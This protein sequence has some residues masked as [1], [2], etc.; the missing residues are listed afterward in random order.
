MFNIKIIFK[1]FKE[2]FGA[3]TLV[4]STLKCTMAD[5]VV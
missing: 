4:R 2:V 1:Q 5:G 3:Y